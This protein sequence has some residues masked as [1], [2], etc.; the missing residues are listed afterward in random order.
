MR[1]TALALIMCLFAFMVA[2][3]AFAD[4][5]SETN[6]QP[7]EG[8]YSIKD[9]QHRVQVT[10][11]HAVN[12]QGS[13]IVTLNGSD[14]QMSQEGSRLRQFTSNYKDLIPGRE[15]QVIAVWY[16]KNNGQAMDLDTCF[17]FKAED[18][19]TKEGKTIKMVDCG[20]NSS[21]KETSTSPEKESNSTP[22]APEKEKATS[23]KEESSKLQN[24]N[25]A[26]KEDPQASV[27][28]PWGSTGIQL[29]LVGCALMGRRH[30]ST[31]RK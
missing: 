19:T 31:H 7:L 6:Q 5:S 24:L 21:P 3:S 26:S 20:F 27:P 15:Y 23:A 1:T 10:L 18:P 2:P 25:S 11:P 9:G 12:P 14:E 30:S 16:G 29:I 8:T 13:W 4:N 22:N 17:Q 28:S